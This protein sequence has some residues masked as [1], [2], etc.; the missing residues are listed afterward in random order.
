MRLLI[1]VLLL[2]ELT[3]CTVALNQSNAIEETPSS[4]VGLDEGDAP[5]ETLVTFEE[6]QRLFLMYHD[7]MEIV[8]E[9]FVLNFEYINIDA[10]SQG[11]LTCTFAQKGNLNDTFRLGSEELSKYTD[12]FEVITFLFDALN[13]SRMSYTSETANNA[14]IMSFVL[15]SQ[16]KAIQGS[17]HLQKNECGIVHSTEPFG[18]YS[19][20]DGDWFYYQS[21]M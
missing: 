4:I 19:Y 15:T 5:E 14:A 20:L 13:L 17:N 1:L 6:A 21:V 2:L 16:T 3:G 7:D 10:D 9:E 8:L 11:K 12:Q 18:E